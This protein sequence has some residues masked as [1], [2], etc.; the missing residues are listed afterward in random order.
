MGPVNDLEDDRLTLMG[1]FVESYKGLAATLERRLERD[2]GLSM[3]WFEVLLRLARSPGH[4]LRMTDLAAQTGLTPS[5]LTRAVDRLSEAGLVE[6]VAC[7]EDRRVAY[8]ALTET[9]LSRVT[10]AVRPHLRDIDE[11]MN[12]ALT[13]PEREQFGALL[14]KVRDHVNPQATIVTTPEPAAAPA[15]GAGG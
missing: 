2:S 12:A 4:R 13:P 1:L 8:A 9:G 3:Q 14:R 6:R 7:P 10:S 15:A 11:L 5:G